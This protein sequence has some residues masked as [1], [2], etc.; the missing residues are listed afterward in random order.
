M[1]TVR[2]TSEVAIRIN[3]IPKSDAEHLARATLQAVERYFKNP[4]VQADYQKWL[5]EYRIRKAVTEC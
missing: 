1:R 3:E 5:A 2:R 4:E